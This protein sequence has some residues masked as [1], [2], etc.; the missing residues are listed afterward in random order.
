MRNKKI[1]KINCFD[2]FNKDEQSSQAKLFYNYYP[3][4]TLNNSKGI[5]NATFPGSLE[6]RTEQPLQITEAGINHV[7]G[8]EYI[9]QYSSYTGNTVHRLLVYGDDNKVYINQLLFDMFE[10]F[11][12]YDLEFDSPPKVLEFKKDDIDTVIL[13][14]NNVMKIWQSGYYPCTIEDV[15]IITSMCMNNGILFCTIKEPKFKIWYATNLDPEQIGNISK[16]SNYVS[17]EDNLGDAKKVI[18]FNEEVYVIRDYGIT[19]LVY[20]HDEIMTSQIYASNTKIYANTVAVCGNNI[21]FMTKEG[22]FNFNG[23]KVNKTKIEL[24]NNFPVENEGATAS[25]LGE[26]YYLALKV[27]FEDGK[28]ILDEENSINNALII[29][30]TEDFSYEII[31]GVDIQSMLPL[32]LDI[33]E[34]MLFTFNTGPIDKIGMLQSGSKFFENNLPKYWESECLTNSPEA[35]LFTKLSVNADMGVKFTLKFD[36]KNVDFTTYKTGIN[37][38]VFKE[39]SKELRL[40]ISSN[41][42]SAIVKD[43]VIEYYEN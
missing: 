20:L 13:T 28:T 3:S 40:E 30:N 27:H 22:L 6:D 29:V 23:V 2:N 14:S 17:L 39:I 35:K 19:K 1:I 5:C 11:H 7:K 38:F 21:L 12:M 10:I 24:L 31:R 8:V 34:R 37:E 4:N 36:D 33:I 18:T 26:S 16:T 42:E 41:E 25:S 43:V 9:K 15:P 32:K